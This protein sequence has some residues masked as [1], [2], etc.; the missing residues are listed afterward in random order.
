MKEY[1]FFMIDVVKELLKKGLDVSWTVYGT[2]QYEASMRERVRSEGLESAITLG[3]PVHHFNVWKALEDAYVFVGMGTA[4]VE[5]ALFKVPALVAIAY[6][7]KGFSYGPLYRMPPGNLGGHHE[8]G[9]KASLMIDEIE[10]ILS[11]S[12]AEYDAEQQL[13]YDFAQSMEI[14]G[15]MKRFLQF[16]QEASP[17]S[18][19]HAMYLL[20]YPFFFIRRMLRFRAR[21]HSNN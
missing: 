11:L 9:L 14:E 5:A 8:D 17:I 19:D 13:V 2:G 15:S 18:S 16:V 21:S 6:D 1:N 10:R 7:G 4:I 12:P 20:N 3:G